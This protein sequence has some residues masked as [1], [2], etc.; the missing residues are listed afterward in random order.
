MTNSRCTLLIVSKAPVP[1][2]VKTR[3]APTIS[4]ADA[5]ELA[6][7]SL[8]DTLDAA[9]RT[10]VTTRVVALTGELSAARHG[11]EIAAA[12]DDFVVIAQRGD[13]FARRLV[14]AHTD[15]AAVAHSPVLQIGM[16]TPQVTPDLLGAAAATLTRPD[17]DAVFGPAADGGWWA[18]GVSTPDMAEV[19]ADITPSRS[20][21]GDRTLRALRQHGW[22]VAHLPVLSD[23]D[24]PDDAKRVAG[25]VDRASRFGAL[26]RRLWR[27]GH[28]D[29]G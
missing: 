25:E 11:G 23:V 10:S 17:V 6:S 26:V 21:T 19:L 9:R 5:A 13:G 4:L 1:G 12:L 29:V 15:A 3:L 27:C 22:R 18:L 2:Q 8:L 20:D 16:D 28:D 7:A 14:N 24:T